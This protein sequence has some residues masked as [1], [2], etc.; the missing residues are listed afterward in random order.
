MTEF[1]QRVKQRRFTG[2]LGTLVRLLERIVTLLEIPTPDPEQVFRRITMMER[3][4]FLP[5]KAAGIGMV[6]Y[7]FH[8]GRW[9]RSAMDE[10]SIA[11]EWTDY[12]LWY[13]IPA[14][15]LIACALLA[16]RRL[17]LGLVQWI[18][19]ISGLLDVVLL[20]AL[21]VLTLDNQSYLYWLF[22]A[23]IIRSAVS[24]PR[25]TSQLV[26]HFTIIICCVITG[27]IQVSIAT[28]LYEK[29]RAERAVARVLSSQAIRL[30]NEPPALVT[31]KPSMLLSNAPPVTKARHRSLRLQSAGTDE[32]TSK[33]ALML[34]SALDRP[35]EPLVT[36]LTLLVLMSV[37]SYG[38]QVLFERQRKAE[39]EAREFAMR[40]GQLHAAGRLAAEFAH[41]IKNPLAI[42]KNALFSLQRAVKNNRPP[43]ADQIGMI[44]EE[45]EHADRIITQ[46]MGYAQLSEGRVEKLDVIEELEKAIA[47]VFPAA[48]IYPIKI[49]R[50][51]AGEFP[52]LL[53]Q[54]R[55]AADA[56]AN[57]LQNAREAFDGK[58]GRIKITARCLPDYA[59]EVSIADNGP[60]IP[61]E[62][63]ERIFE[64]Y[65]TTKEEGTGLGLATVKHNVELYGGSIRVESALGKGARFTLLFPGRTHIKTFKPPR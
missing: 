25:A 6:L 37:C 16:M 20:S 4:I 55:H 44:Q 8:Y 59:I 56:F 41:Q 29:F 54:R 22:L 60:G 48:A 1:W 65:Y 34:A 47:Q 53:M 46:I 40:E 9:I 33:E 45:V 19:F 49:E 30:T 7:S 23:L 2:L 32:E 57:I 12:F 11:V 28:N 31:N 64:A 3:D 27:I 62:K 51:F 26:L 5:L 38:V 39:E 13:Y 10:L 61:P 63:Q 43:P 17:P 50:D 58:A 24:V 18:V 15:I 21:T 52:P 36:R 42:I 14:N 35:A